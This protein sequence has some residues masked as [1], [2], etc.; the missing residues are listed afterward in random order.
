MIS[1][2]F[3]P[4]LAQQGRRLWKAALHFAAV[5]GAELAETFYQPFNFYFGALIVDI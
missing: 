2:N 4:G 5:A 1:T 3:Q